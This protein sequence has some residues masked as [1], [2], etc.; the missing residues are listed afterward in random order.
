M[1]EASDVDEY[2][3]ALQQ[4]L[5]RL[6]DGDTRLGGLGVD[7][8]PG[9]GRVPEDALRQ[10][11]LSV[12]EDG[13][14]VVRSTAYGRMATASGGEL[15]KAALVRARDSDLVVVDLRREGPDLGGGRRLGAHLAAAAPL[16]IDRPL[17]LT[18]TRRRMHS[19]F[20]WG[21]ASR[22]FYSAFVQAQP[23]RLM[24]APRPDDAVPKSSSRPI[25]PAVS[26]GE[27]TTLPPIIFFLNRGTPNGVIP[28]LGG[29]RSQ[30]LARIVY[31]GP[32]PLGLQ[33]GAGHRVDLP[34][35]LSA[36][37]RLNQWLHA[38]GQVGF[39]P[40]HVIGGEEGEHLED[41]VRIARQVLERTPQRR[42]LEA[43]QAQALIAPRQ[44]RLASEDES[45]PALER[46]LLGL[47]RYWNVF[48]YF[49]PYKDLLDEP[50]EQVL[51]E[52]IPIFEGASDAR[53]YHLAAARLAART[54]DSLSLVNSPELTEYFGPA[55]PGF[56][57]KAVEGQ[58]V[59]FEILKPE[60][61]EGLEVGDVIE[62]VDGLSVDQHV[63]RLRPYLSASTPQAAQLKA[64][65]NL[66]GGSE[67]SMID[68]T[69]R[70]ADGSI[71]EV[72]LPRGMGRRRLSRTRPEYEVLSGG[73]GYVDLD[74]LSAGEAPLAYQAVQDAWAIVFDLRGYPQGAV[75]PLASLL[76]RESVPAAISRR[77]EP[78]S[79]DLDALHL[80]EFTIR[81]P[82]PRGRPYS[83]RVVVLINEETIS[84]GERACLILDAVADVTFVGTPS[85]GA[86]GEIA[87]VPL[88]GG[89]RAYLTVQS[90]SPA[91]GRPLQRHGIQ[92]HVRAAPTLHSLRQGRDQVL[93]AALDYLR[94]SR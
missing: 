17:T 13:A 15:L 61:A 78:S 79:P 76:G 50:W 88:P 19:G 32:P 59:V 12:L 51:S 80:L 90:L 56:V 57:I 6:E 46:R 41:L 34:H 66:L 64:Y 83:G 27:L 38:D 48:H 35:R 23:Q 60:E 86:A 87:V 62:E 69:V 40:D 49:S 75:W 47:F 36:D 22:S 63:E 94:R 74:R 68:L 29:L 73:I 31:Q 85:N 65:S 9:F 8:D 1:S 45:F 71:S 58:P 25:R 37:I 26:S 72:S 10:P 67:G 43:S 33:G 24:P 42:L 7:R 11:Y 14:A 5:D 21:Q 91:D 54:Q 18:T 28:V 53:N 81:T 3:D 44:P 82:Q 70:K 92:P 2:R 77:P 93:E 16:L 30:G 39:Q 4:M 84:R 55:V 89:L 20:A 52:F